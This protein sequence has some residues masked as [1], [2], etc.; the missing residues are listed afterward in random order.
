MF[1]Y[2]MNASEGKTRNEVGFWKLLQRKDEDK[3]TTRETLRFLNQQYSPK[4]LVVGTAQNLIWVV[5]IQLYCIIWFFKILIPVAN[6]F[7]AR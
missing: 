1:I 5:F 4:E 2:M 7:Y 3:K 6:T